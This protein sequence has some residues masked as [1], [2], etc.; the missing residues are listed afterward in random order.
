[1]VEVKM[2]TR[3]IR[4]LEDIAIAKYPL[5]TMAILTS[6]NVNGQYVVID[7][8]IGEG[9]GLINIVS[10]SPYNL[11]V[12]VDFDGIKD[13]V[14]GYWHTHPMLKGSDGPE[15]LLSLAP[16]EH[17]LILLYKII[18]RYNLDIS[19][20]SIS[21]IAQDDGAR[22]KIATAIYIVY[23]SNKYKLKLSSLSYRLR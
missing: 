4:D 9:S 22:I 15:L 19:I 5:E 11:S 16:S 21:A 12:E 18:N 3:V 17:D 20:L 8:Y 7:G 14:V 13:N 2:S 6:S 10:R 1:M 23:A